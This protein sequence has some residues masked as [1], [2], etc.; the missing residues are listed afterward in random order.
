MNRTEIIGNLTA[1]PL[2]R[3]VKGSDGIMVKVCNFDV[4]INMHSGKGEYAVYYHVTTWRQ[5]AE[6]CFKYLDK[7]SKVFVD[8]VV[9]ANLYQ[10]KNGKWAAGLNLSANSVEFLSPAKQAQTPVN[11]PRYTG[12]ARMLPD[13]NAPDYAEGDELP[14]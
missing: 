12:I 3:E 11:K 6:L 4:A 2:L 7:G 14:F 5:Q 10:D 9:S 1:K 13:N 8:G